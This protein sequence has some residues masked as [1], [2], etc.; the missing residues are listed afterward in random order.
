MVSI[1]RQEKCKEIVVNCVENISAV[2]AFPQKKFVFV[3]TDER[4]ADCEIMS[5]SIVLWCTGVGLEFEFF[6]QR[7]GICKMFRMSFVFMVRGVPGVNHLFAIV[8][9]DGKIGSRVLFY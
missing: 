7:W 3:S 9:H 6:G 8:S 1:N 2:Y 4:C 5:M